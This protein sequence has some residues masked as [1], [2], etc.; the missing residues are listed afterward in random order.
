[1]SLYH[2]VKATKQKEWAQRYFAISGEKLMYGKAKGEKF[3]RRVDLKGCEAAPDPRRTS[4]KQIKLHTKSR[5][6]FYLRCETDELMHQWVDA[7]NAAGGA[8]QPAPGTPPRKPS[9]QET[10]APP[11][12]PEP[13]PE[14][15][16]EPPKAPEPPKEEP[17]KEEKKESSSDSSSD[18]DELSDES[19]DEESSDESDEEEEEE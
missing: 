3:T 12:A 1:M 6:N 15:T 8:T 7:L 5:G 16:P 11:A 17:K 10:P 14:P 9:V 2:I 18:E 19:F 4:R 13:T